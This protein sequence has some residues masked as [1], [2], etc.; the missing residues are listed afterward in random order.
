MLFLERSL[1]NQEFTVVCNIRSHPEN[2]DREL[3]SMWKDLSAL[4]QGTGT[5]RH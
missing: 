3:K 5:R 1:G 4:S 2:N